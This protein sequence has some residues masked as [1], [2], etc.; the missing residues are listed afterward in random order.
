V[1]YEQKGVI[2]YRKHPILLLAGIWK[3]SLLILGVVVAIVLRL[4]QVF[5]WLSVPVLLGLG[6]IALL[7]LS[8]W[9]IYEYVDWRND[10]YQVT[11]DQIIDVYKKPLGQEEKKIASLENI[12]S[13]QHQ[14]KGLLGLLL[15]YGDVIA[16]VGGTPFTF[17]GV[18]NPAAVEQDI[19][20][21]IRIRKRQ[22]KES[23]DAQERERVADWM[24]AYHR[25]MEA[26]RRGENRPKFDRNS[27]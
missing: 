13:L 19:F 25:Q 23:A 14:R 27:G 20:D 24:A 10:V 6:F 16:M 3:P 15:N 12:L 22:Q 2:T 7:G 1:R 8:V 18:L 26:L 9:W 5:T 17:D 11:P 4:A 21:R